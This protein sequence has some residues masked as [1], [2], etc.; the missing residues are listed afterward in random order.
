MRTKIAF[1]KNA[2]HLARLYLRHPYR[3][4]NTAQFDGFNHQHTCLLARVSP[5]HFEQLCPMASKGK[6]VAGNFDECECCRYF[7]TIRYGFDAERDE[8]QISVDTDMCKGSR[9]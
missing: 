8:K 3:V 9:L 5:M 4:Y 2:C 7:G 6:F 1:L